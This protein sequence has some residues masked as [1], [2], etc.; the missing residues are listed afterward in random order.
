MNTL[1]LTLAPERRIVSPACARTD[2]VVSIHEAPMV[3]RHSYV[4]GKREAMQ[5]Q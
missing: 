1:T 4:T 5:L 2:R 3:T